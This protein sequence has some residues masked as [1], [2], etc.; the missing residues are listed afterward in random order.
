MH[1]EGKYE[2]ILNKILNVL[3]A[4]WAHR[5]M[6]FPTGS[7]NWVLNRSFTVKFIILYCTSVLLIVKLKKKQQ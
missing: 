3:E 6:L 5:D 1:I 2:Y 4:F 7:L